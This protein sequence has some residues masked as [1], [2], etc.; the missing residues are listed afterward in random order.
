VPSS[1]RRLGDSGFLLGS[2][3]GWL[4]WFRL[5]EDRIGGLDGMGWDR[6]VVPSPG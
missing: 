3:V 5:F 6:I 4:L 1:G 2:F